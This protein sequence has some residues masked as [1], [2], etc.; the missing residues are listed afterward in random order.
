[1][2]NEGY[3]ERI[4]DREDDCGAEKRRCFRGT[5]E[6]EERN[7]IRLMLKRTGCRIRDQGGA[8]EILAFQS[9]QTRVSDEQTRN[10]Q[11]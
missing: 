6:E 5:A 8:A 9:R 10:R 7:H 2:K 3:C 4:D 11:K 1:M